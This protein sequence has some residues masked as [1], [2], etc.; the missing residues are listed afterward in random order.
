MDWSF[1]AS[2][3]DP[4][5]EIHPYPA[6]FIPAIPAAA[7]SLAPPTGLILDPFSGIG[8]TLVES[9]RRGRSA[10]GVD[11]NPIATLVAQAKLSGWTADDALALPAMKERLLKAGAAGN[12]ELQLEAQEV[13]PRLDHWFSPVA[14]ETLAGCVGFLRGL[15]EEDP[16][17]IRLGAA[18]SSVVV[19]S[20][21]QESDTRYA[22]IEKNV[23][24]KSILS[25]VSRA[26]EK[27]ARAAFLVQ[28]ARPPGVEAASITDDCAN[29]GSHV[30]AGTVGSAIFSPPY[31]N[32]YEYWLYHKYRMYWLGFDPLAVRE[33][34]IGARPFYSGSGKS[35]EHDFEL[36]MEDLFRSLAVAMIPG[37][38]V[39]T[40]VGDS[41]IRGRLID[42][43]ELTRRAAESQGFSPIAA[44]TRGIRRT[45]R[46]FNLAVAR[47]KSEHVLLFIKP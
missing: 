38:T 30:G 44:T 40:V 29:L 28:A 42:N 5:H 8:T 24:A 12:R 1:P 15:P 23:S 39:L 9:V 35:T 31:P 21:R 43:G 7:L 46:S 18:V 20:S 10:I 3:A 4:V 22:A 33:H 2:E 26:V 25:S 16:W 19:R 14:Q 6:R 47:A 45:R 36:Q 32:A 34:E 11:L 13:I 41:K 37:G 27:V 17:R